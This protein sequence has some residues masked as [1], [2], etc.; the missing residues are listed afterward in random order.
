MFGYHPEHH[1]LEDLVI[2]VVYF[3]PT[4]VAVIRRHKAMFAIFL[5][6]FILGITLIGW[7]GALVWALTNPNPQPKPAKAHSKRG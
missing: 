7:I 1:L 5:L 4:W 6:N 2:I 3:I